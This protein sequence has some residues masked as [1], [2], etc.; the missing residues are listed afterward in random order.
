M[1]SR[2][3]RPAACAG[4][5]CRAGAR[6]G[7]RGPRRRR[8]PGRRERRPALDDDA[9]RRIRESRELGT[10]NLV[11]GARAPPTRR[12]R[13]LVSSSAVGYYGPHGDERARRG[14]PARRRLPRRGVRRLGARGRSRPRSSACASCTSAPAS[15]STA[16]AARW[17]RCCRR[18]SSASAAR[19]P[20]AS[21]T[22]RGSTSTTSS[23]STSRALDDDALDAAPVNA[24]APEPVTNQEFSQGAR[25]AR[26]TARR[27]RPIPALRDPR[28]STA[29]WREIVTD[30]PARRPAAHARARLPFAHPDLDEAL[31]AAVG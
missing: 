30:G 22:C 17:R 14:H 10:R 21:S 31:R 3:R 12:P 9:K 25:A 29:T 11:A 23:A 20:A 24:T 8:P 19:S 26:C 4:T 13:A 7:A 5:R 15:C 18:S 27:S 28:C 16:T 1:L 6:R 2:S